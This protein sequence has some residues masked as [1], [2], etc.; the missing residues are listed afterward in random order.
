L[1]AQRVLKRNEDAMVI[2][3][4]NRPEDIHVDVAADICFFFGDL[5]YRVHR[6]P[7]ET[8]WQLVTRGKGMQLF[9]FDQL[10]EQ[11]GEVRVEGAGFLVFDIMYGPTLLPHV[12]QGA[13]LDRFIEPP[14][15]FGPTYRMEVG[16]KQYGNKV[17]GRGRAVR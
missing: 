15:Q 1:V 14:V 10:K 12:V 5:N 8:A 3:S 11:M 9:H 6:V 7:W 2:L 17:C 4:A 13:V 16:T